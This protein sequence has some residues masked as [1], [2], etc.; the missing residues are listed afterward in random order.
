[1]R[2][3]RLLAGALAAVLSLALFDNSP[4]HSMAP[5]DD[6]SATTLTGACY[7][8]PGRVSF[9]VHPP[10]DGTYQVEITARGLPDGSRWL[11]TPGAD[12]TLLGVFRR[13]AVDGGWTIATQAP[14]PRNPDS[15]VYFG[16]D[17]RERG[18]RG[19]RC[20]MYRPSSPVAGSATCENRLIDISLLYREQEDGSMLL[21]SR[22]FARPDS[23]WH[24]TLTA[25][26]AASRQVVEFDDW[27]GGQGGVR[28]Q[29]VITGVENPRLRLVATNKDKGRCFIGL[30]P[31]D[32]N[33]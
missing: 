22:L 10:A 13:V 4:A 21:R 7:G 31:P 11:V 33:A 17:A 16:V 24:L 8:G 26:G 3:P 20:L 6:P 23:R 25:S 30:D 27:A 32:T 5:A 15:V 19:H 12:N 18:D 29:V 1:M 28:S 2:T 14:A 9:T